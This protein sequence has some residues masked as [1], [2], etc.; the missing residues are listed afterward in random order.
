MSDIPTSVRGRVL[1]FL[2][3]DGGAWTADVLAQEL[4]LPTSKVRG[5]LGN[6]AAYHEVAAVAELKRQRGQ[7]GRVAKAY[8]AVT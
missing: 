8:Q 3:A 1:A 4:G 5:A 2:K 7:K 6:L